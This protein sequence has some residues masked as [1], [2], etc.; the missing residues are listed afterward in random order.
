MTLAACWKPQQLVNA[1][2]EPCK[3]PARPHLVLNTEVCQEDKVCMSIEMAVQLAEWMAADAEY[4]IAVKRCPMVEV[5]K[6]LPEGAAEGKQ[7]AKDEYKL[8]PLRLALVADIEVVWKDCGEVNGYYV[9]A[10][11]II[12]MCNELKTL[13]PGVVRFVFA[14]ELSHAVIYQ[15]DIPY[16]GSEEWAADELATLILIQLGDYEALVATVDMFAASGGG[17]ATATS[18]PSHERRALYISCLALESLGQTQNQCMVDY[19]RTKAAWM[20]L[21]RLPYA[22]EFRI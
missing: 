20:K 22:K 12:V 16:T 10:S 15:R 6:A 9:I 11:K 5:V 17:E 3:V 4:H 2:I 14:H 19:T 18:H 8:A 13:D 7:P 21:L 1:P